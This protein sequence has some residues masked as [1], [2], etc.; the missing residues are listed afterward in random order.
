VNLR[1]G[2]FRLWIVGAA[3]FVLAVAFASYS[4]IEEEFE[5]AASVVLLPVPHPEVI[6]RFQEGSLKP[7]TDPTLIKR[8]ER[9]PNPWA[10]LG[11]A[12]AIA[13]GIPLTILA[14]GSSLLWAL[15]GSAVTRQP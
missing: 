10:S 11:T 8:L 2:L 14:L 12:A 9:T 4:D 13:F 5:D 15:S 7:V 3:L 6:K 1:R